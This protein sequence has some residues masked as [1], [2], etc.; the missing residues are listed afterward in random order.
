MAILKA[1]RKL[2]QERADNVRSAIIAFAKSKGVNVDPSQIQA[3]GL[4]P[5]EPEVAKPTNP[6]VDSER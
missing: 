1:L 4:G 3:V 6:A 5:R 2:S